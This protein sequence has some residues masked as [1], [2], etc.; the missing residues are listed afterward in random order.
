MDTAIAGG[1]GNI[2]H[3]ADKLVCPQHFMERES[4]QLARIGATKRAKDRIMADTYGSKQE[5]MLQFGLAD[6]D[7]E[8]D[9][10]VKFLNLQD[11]WEE[12]V[13]SYNLWFERH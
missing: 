2:F 7:E 4:M 9:F 5:T 13:S 3:E 6:A 8:D 11:V 1:L 12:V 10:N